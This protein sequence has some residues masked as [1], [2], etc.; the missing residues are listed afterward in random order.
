VVR[1]AFRLA[2]GDPEP[3]SAPPALGA[4]TENILA[5]LGY[6]DEAISGLRREGAI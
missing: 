2:S 5:Q 1:S 3:P 4:D 6:D